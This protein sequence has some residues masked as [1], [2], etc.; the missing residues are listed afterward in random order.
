MK[1]ERRPM[2]SLYIMCIAL[3][4]FL[5]TMMGGLLALRLRDQRHL[6][7]G[8]SAGA[9]IALAFFDL[10]PEALKLGAPVFAPSTVLAVAALGFFAYTV[11]DRS[12]PGTGLGGRCKPVG[13]QSDGWFRDRH[14][15]PRLA[16]DRSR[17]GCRCAGA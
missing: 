12:E 14:G 4:A 2:Q 9:I 16:R 17:C 13:S 1:V 7:L 11:L 3:G 8:F 5:A 6:I 10:L 15:V